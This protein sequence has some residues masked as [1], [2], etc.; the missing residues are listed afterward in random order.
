MQE[1]AHLF[2]DEGY[3]FGKEG[4]GFERINIACP[5]KV[6]MDALNRLNDAIKRLDK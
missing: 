2:L 5:T 3:I 1:D 4:I 6:L